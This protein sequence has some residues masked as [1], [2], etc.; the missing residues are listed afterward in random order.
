MFGNEYESSGGRKGNIGISP[1]VTYGDIKPA[2]PAALAEEKASLRG[3][4][5]RRGLRPYMLSPPVAVGGMW[6]AEKADLLPA[7]SAPGS[8]TGG[9]I[10]LGSESILFSLEL[11]MSSIDLTMSPLQVLTVD[12]SMSRF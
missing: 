7:A 2:I 11:R 3:P 8:P 5:P 12:S 6:T 1:D 10:A 4:I 9:L